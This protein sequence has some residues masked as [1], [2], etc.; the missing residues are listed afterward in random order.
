MYRFT[1]LSSPAPSVAASGSVALSS[2]LHL[3][4]LVSGRDSCCNRDAKFGRLVESGCLQIIII[5]L[6]CTWHENG[7]SV[8]FLVCGF[9]L[10]AVHHELVDNPR[11]SRRWGKTYSIDN[12]N[13]HAFSTCMH[14]KWD[15]SETP[16]L[17]HDTTKAPHITGSRVLLVVYCLFQHDLCA[18]MI[19][20]EL[21]IEKL[22][23]SGAVHLMGTFPPREI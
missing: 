8:Y 17:I 13:L 1:A 19:S 22:L 14:F 15:M 7:L 12:S 2:S 20:K 9:H 6:L 4:S 18:F 5:L 21:Y 23:T 10:P 11:A 3:S 16:Y